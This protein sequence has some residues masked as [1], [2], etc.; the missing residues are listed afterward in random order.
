MNTQADNFIP[1]HQLSK[2]RDMLKVLPE[3][4]NRFPSQSAE[5]GGGRWENKAMSSQA[6]ISVLKN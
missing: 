2:N 3:H 4:H 1:V 5:A 6:D